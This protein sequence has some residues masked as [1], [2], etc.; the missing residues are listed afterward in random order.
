MLA[1]GDAFALTVARANGFR[2]KDF[3]RNH[4]AGALALQFRRVDSE[5]RC[6]ERLVRVLPNT[7][8][9]E[10]VRRVSEGRTGAAVLLDDADRL[11]GIFTDGDLR[12][13]L[14]NGDSVLHRPVSEFDRSMS[15]DSSVESWQRHSRYF[16]KPESK[17]YRW[18]MMIARV[19]GLLCLKTFP[20]SECFASSSA[21]VS[22]ASSPKRSSQT[23]ASGLLRRVCENSSTAVRRRSTARRMPQCPMRTCQ[24]DGQPYPCN[25]SDVVFIT[26]RFRSGSTL[27][28]NIFRHLD[29]CTAYYE[30]FNERRWFRPAT[31]GETDTT[32]L[33]A[34]SEI[35][36]EY[37][38]L[39]EL[40]SLY[41]QSWIEES[42]HVCGILESAD[43]GLCRIVNQTF[44][45][46]A[47]AAVQ[48]N[49]LP[50]AVVPA[51]FSQCE[52][53]IH[54]PA[55]ARRNGVRR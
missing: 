27:L 33:I 4:P 38:G 47:G 32:E 49:R 18:W 11:V 50:P 37:D 13:A 6:D 22:S 29:G 20:Y 36:G 48:P 16:P 40:S 55:P 28:W 53:C 39:A 21:T 17:T 7:L 12:R 15:C 26:G 10:V 46:A 25:R 41:D 1:V 35:T 23:T 2:A 30:P 43:E 42:L 24:P 14:L 51:E 45:R 3:A 34:A 54:L 44:G 52:G 9:E 5:M 31:R 19:V 8:V